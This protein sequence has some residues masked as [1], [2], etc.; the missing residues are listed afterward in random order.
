[1]GRYL[2][3]GIATEMYFE[4]QRAEKVFGDINKAIE[5]VRENHA[6]EDVYDLL[7]GNEC[8]G[9]KM[10]DKIVE[11][12]LVEFLS[13]FYADRMS[14]DG[15]SEETDEILSALANIS[16]TDE[17]KSL[18]EDNSM[19]YF[20]YDEYWDPIFIETD[21]WNRMVVILRGI[22]LSLDGKI[23]MECYGSIMSYF[24]S[25]LRDRYRKYALSKSLYVTISG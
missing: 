2:V 25:V 13:A 19:V 24:T 12:E 17:I 14:N 10:K 7:E 3:I 23:I 9:F 1:M 21:S 16:T 5:Y 18:A 6:P 20:Q 11:T 22:D 15:S 8:I 4:R